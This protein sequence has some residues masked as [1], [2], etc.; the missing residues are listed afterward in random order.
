[1]RL[2]EYRVVINY[3]YDQKES[4][5]FNTLKK[6]YTAFMS[7]E[8]AEKVKGLDKA[9]IELESFNPTIL[10]WENVDTIAPMQEQSSSKLV[11]A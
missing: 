4:T 1:M 7:K 3:G 5:Y 6:A 8:T 11:T 10:V 2:E 9:I